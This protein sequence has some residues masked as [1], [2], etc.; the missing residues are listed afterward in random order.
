MNQLKEVKFKLLVHNLDI[1]VKVIFAVN[2]RIFSEPNF[3]YIFKA[4][5][6]DD[7]HHIFLLCNMLIC[8]KIE[9][10]VTINF[11]CALFFL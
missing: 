5:G 1:L 6:D 3:K 10:K 8:N 2:M 4:Y 9:G 7:E 11:Y